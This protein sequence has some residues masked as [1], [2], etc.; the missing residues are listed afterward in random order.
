MEIKMKYSTMA[1][2]TMYNS[3]ENTCRLKNAD[4]MNKLSIQFGYG[5]PV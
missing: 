2:V 1:L 5:I 3:Q 4:G